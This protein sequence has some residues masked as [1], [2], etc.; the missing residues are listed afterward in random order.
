M[1]K[2]LNESRVNMLAGEEED[3]KE[4]EDEEEGTGPFL[5]TPSVIKVL[6]AEGGINPGLLTCARAHT[7]FSPLYLKIKIN[8]SIDA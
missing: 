4:D 1:G 7:I 6:S 3:N 2:L 8:L 5:Q